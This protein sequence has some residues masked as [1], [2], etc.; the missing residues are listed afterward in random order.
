[1]KV[2]CFGDSNTYGYDPRSFF[3]DQYKKD[4]R[5]VDILAAITGWEVVNQGEN[6][7]QIPKKAVSFP[8][9]MDLLIVMLGTNDLLEG[10]TAE[11]TAQK[12][13]HFLSALPLEKNKILLIAPP[14][15]VRGEW[16]PNQALIESS[17]S[18]CK[19]Y[20]DLAR[21]MVIRFANA[22]EWGVSMAY[23]GVHYTEYGHRAFAEGLLSALKVLKIF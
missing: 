21:R 12:I 6:G 1:M 23:D 2:I 20:Q 9:D 3:G 16:V 7:R 11:Q 14:P 15:M 22:G 17:A 18:L 8:Q 4:A 5:W 19:L 10:F 13:E